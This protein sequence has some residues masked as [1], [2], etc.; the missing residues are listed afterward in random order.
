MSYILK[1]EAHILAF[2]TPVLSTSCTSCYML[3]MSKTAHVR[4]VNSVTNL[5]RSS[6][7]PLK[8]VGEEPCYSI[9]AIC[10]ANKQAIIEQHTREARHCHKG[11]VPLLK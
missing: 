3:K 10:R 1:N 7:T 5:V 9:L 11:D 6:Q 8:S 4:V 2:L